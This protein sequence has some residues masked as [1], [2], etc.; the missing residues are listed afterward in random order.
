VARSGTETISDGQRQ[1][2][3]E[4][5]EVAQQHPGLIQIVGNGSRG[6]YLWLG[7]R[8]ST[9]GMHIAEGGLRIRTDH[10]QVTLLV[11]PSFPWTP[12]VATVTH[13]RFLGH[14]HVLQGD[15]LCVYLDPDREWHPAQG[16]R[17]FLNRLHTWFTDAAA[18]RFD[19]TTALYH[20]V[21]GVVHRTPGTPTIVVRQP[22]PA[23]SRPF[24]RAALR[25]RS[26]HRLD[27]TDWTPQGPADHLALVMVLNEQ[28]LYGAGTTV[29]DLLHRLAR[30][31]HGTPGGVA[32]L[33]ARTA[34][35]NPAG[36]TQYVIIAV[37]HQGR[38]NGH[39]LLA[40]RI[41]A[42]LTDQLRAAASG[43]G[44]A[45]HINP[46]AIPDAPI[47]WCI[48]SDERPQMTTRRDTTRPTTGYIGKTVELWGCGALG[49]WI[50]EFIARAGAARIVLRD[51]GHVQ[52]GLLVRQN[53]LE[54]DIGGNKAHQL[55]ER[56]QQISDSLT[57]QA[58]STP[59]PAAPD[60]DSDLLIDATVTN[61]TGVY[62]DLLAREP[63]R[64]PRPPLARAA[65]DLHTATLGLLAIAAHGCPDGP[66]AIDDQAG[67]LVLADG[68]LERF[69]PFWQE[70]AAGDEVLP[71]RG[72]SVPTFHGSAADVAATAA[73]LASL[74]AAHISSGVSGTHLAALPH[75]PGSGPS[76]QFL[77]H[78]EGR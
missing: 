45:L 39:H 52:G 69:H 17:G 67:K 63:G 65:T 22:L 20:P 6:G 60:P 43:Q 73:V 3:R 15:R 21:G 66:N 4:L 36:T 70:P 71:A 13:E 38:F 34:A 42:D 16:I 30:I 12:P 28:L 14:P 32:T 49:S 8:L 26:E 7:V 64:T 68:K 76:H 57:V 61:S 40:G 53:Y 11:P 78:R 56:L 47:E 77:P 74:L 33:L 55:A 75:A 5:R 62:L 19:P 25:A 41:P 9:A 50:A 23:D 35:R 46:Q 31:G 24:F 58:D 59:A 27:L 10:E 48:A 29:P 1:A 37:P 2:R 72:C 18:G 44:T 51:P 54:T